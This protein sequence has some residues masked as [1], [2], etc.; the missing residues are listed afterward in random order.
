ML[1]GLSASL[2]TQDATIDD[3][4]YTLSLALVDASQL[5]TRQ[6]TL[7]MQFRIASE[8]QQRLGRTTSG[9][10]HIIKRFL[11]TRDESLRMRFPALAQMFY[12]VAHGTHT[13]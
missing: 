6:A 9:S 2:S 13:I 10:G 4:R 7:R 11:G 8:H 3:L 12:S 5:K 1:E